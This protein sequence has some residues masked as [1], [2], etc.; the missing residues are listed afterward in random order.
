MNVKSPNRFTIAHVKLS[1]RH[2]DSPRQSD[3]VFSLIPSTLTGSFILS[4]F[5]WKGLSSHPLHPEKIC[6]TPFILK[7]IC[8]LTLSTL[9]RSVLLPLSPWQGLSSYPFTLKRSVILPPSPWKGL[10]FYPLHP[11]QVCH[12]TPFTLSVSVIL[13]PW[14]WSDNGHIF[15][16]NPIDE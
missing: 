5:T 10:S 12:L 8:H 13:S 1:L 16:L 14:R 6:H 7:K 9:K 11:E 15:F 3:L 2:N 4:P